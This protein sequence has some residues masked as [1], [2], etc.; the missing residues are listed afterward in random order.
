[1]MLNFG[2]IIINI[3]GGLAPRLSWRKKGLCAALALFLALAFSGPA[4]AE[5]GKGT[6]QIG[7]S[8]HYVWPQM[9][10]K[11][12]EPN[13]D[14]GLVFHYWLNRTTTIMVGF[15]QLEFEVPF[16]VDGEDEDLGFSTGV[17]E[18]GVRYQARVDLLAKPY[19]EAGLGYQTWTI[20]P[21]ADFLDSRNGGRVIYF[22]GAGLSGQL[23][24]W[25]A[26]SLNL[27]YFYMPMNDEIEREAVSVGVDT[28]AVDEDPL[29]NLG[30]FSAGVE[31]VWRFK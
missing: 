31:L 16:E 22:A 15:E 10:V 14:W 5:V 4:L 9:D 27:R 3:A 23:G 25:F 2:L 13:Y 24:Y 17:L 19:V 28:Y 21:G 20:D 11:D 1:M 6:M 12:F 29:E 30:F 7:L 18:L 26:A 8:T